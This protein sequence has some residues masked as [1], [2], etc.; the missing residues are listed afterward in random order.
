MFSVLGLLCP[1]SLRFES[2]GFGR[3]INILDEDETVTSFTLRDIVGANT[4]LTLSDLI[5]FMGLLIP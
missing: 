1:S 2:T 3:K 4:G 5:S